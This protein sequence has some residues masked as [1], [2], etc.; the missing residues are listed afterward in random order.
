L[1]YNPHDSVELKLAHYMGLDLDGPEM[2]RLKWAGVFDD[3][4]VGLDRG[5]PAQILEHILKKKW[6]LD[7]KDRDMI[8]MWHKFEYLENGEGKEKEINSTLIVEGDDAVSTAMSKTVGLPI[9]IATKLILNE[10]IDLKGVQ[11]PTKPQIYVPILEELGA[12]GFVM[13]EEQVK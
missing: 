3:E 13:K 5:T 7:D 4:L 9:G 2:H 12:L 10:K 8:V 6:T 1:S 11:I